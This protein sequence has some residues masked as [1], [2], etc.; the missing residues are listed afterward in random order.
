MDLIFIHVVLQLSLSK[1]I[2]SDNDQGNK[3]VDKEERK[4]YEEHNVKDGHLDTEPGLRSLFFV[5][6]GHGVLKYAKKT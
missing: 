4:Y 6:W 2:E 5:R 1:L 3:N